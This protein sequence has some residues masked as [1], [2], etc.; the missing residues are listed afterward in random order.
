MSLLINPRVTIT[1]TNGEPIVAA[2]MYV[3]EADTTTIKDIWD[4]SA[5]SGDPTANPATSDANGTFPAVYVGGEHKIVFKDSGGTE[6]PIGADNIQA[7]TVPSATYDIEGIVQFASGA[8]VQSKTPGFVINTDNIDDIPI[9]AGSVSGELAV[10]NIPNLPAT[11]ITSATLDAARLP[12]ATET[13]IGAV[14]KATASEVT[15]GTADKYVDAALLQGA[16]SAIAEATFT[17]AGN[18]WVKITADTGDL[19]IQWDTET[20]TPNTS[21]TITLAETYADTTYAAI[22]TANDASASRSEN[23]GAVVISASQLQL[24]SGDSSVGSLF[25]LTIGEAA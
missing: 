24:W 25:W 12:A 5:L 11:K 3:Y 15:A 10:N 4:N 22:V 14:E 16:L 19:L 7:V 8:Q 23:N 1:D 6:I 17:G 9:A 20:V 2:S 21:T 13:A 18:K